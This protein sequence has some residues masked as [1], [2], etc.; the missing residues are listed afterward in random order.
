MPRRSVWLFL[1]VLGS[2]TPCKAATVRNVP[3]T[4]ATIQAAIDASVSGD[5][6]QIAAG[7]YSGSGNYNLDL[8]GKAIT[9]ISTSGPSATII[10]C[11]G[12]GRGFY[13]H[14][15]ETTAARISGLTIRGGKP[16]IP[17]YTYL[18]NGGGILIDSSNPTIDNCVLTANEAGWGGGIAVMHSNYADTSL[19]QPVIKGCTFS[20]NTAM[21]GGG[22]S[23]S[24]AV[25]LVQ[26]ITVE[27][28][29]ASH[30]AG[31]FWGGGGNSLPVGVIQNA[32]ILQN[33]APSY[34]M[35]GGIAVEYANLEVR[36]S[37]I[38]ENSA[39][40]YGGGISYH[41]YSGKLTLVGNTIAGNV[42]PQGRSLQLYAA[43]G[44]QVTISNSI[45][46]NGGNE[47]YD[48]F[49]SGTS[50]NVITISYS[51]V[52]GGYAGTGN[53]NADPLFKDTAAGDYHLLLKSPCRNTGDPA[54]VAL[55]GETD[56]DG[57]ARILSRRVDIG[58][59]ESRLR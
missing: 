8:K 48:D 21:N 59:D 19:T 53:L 56:M 9:V 11:K 18:D 22:L 2:Q 27:Q 20:G 44:N 54:Y 6:V 32:I 47:L 28:N 31:V 35:G 17:N 26:W 34:G 12:V 13:L 55:T 5:T 4:Y 37:L 40:Q 38:A 16:T 36:D 7:T 39:S 3:S 43:T 15:G 10:D 58:A 24:N 49:S 50:T 45:L 33:S 25:P 52:Y 23:V 14:S 1:L 46:Y 57:D 30:G 51:D 29:T 42:S 41:N